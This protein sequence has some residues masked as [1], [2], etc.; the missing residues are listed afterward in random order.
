MNSKTRMTKEKTR[1]I[2]IPENMYYNISI[3]TKACNKPVNEI[4]NDLLTL[5]TQALD[6][7]MRARGILNKR[8]DLE[9]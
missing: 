3:Y 6:V 1:K 2:A 5:G 4:A 7:H 9:R 8:P